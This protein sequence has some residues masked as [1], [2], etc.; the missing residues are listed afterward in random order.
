VTAM[1]REGEL[2]IPEEDGI[3][4]AA[5]RSVDERMTT[6]LEMKV[7][8]RHNPKLRGALDWVNANDDLYGLWLAS[9]VTAIER[10]GMTDH[11]PVHVKIVMNLAVRLLRLLVEGGVEP[12]VTPALR[13]GPGGRRGGGG[14]GRALPR[15]GD[16][17]SPGGPRVL[18]PLPGPR[19]PEGAP[20]GS[21][22]S[23]GRRPS[24]APRSSTPSSA[25]GQGGS[26]SP[27]RRGWCASPMPWTWPRD[28][29]GS[30]SRPDR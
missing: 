14:A 24:S 3:P 30:P 17:H 26:P 13:D 6:R 27:W 11:G 9:N 21:T 20:P 16:V 18:L 8:V 10:L 22:P 2:V 23:R 15:P 12:S 5:P 1:D 25:T 4:D 19:P 29:P 7:P 28:A